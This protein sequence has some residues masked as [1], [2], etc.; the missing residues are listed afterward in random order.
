MSVRG[1]DDG[2]GGD[3]DVER[4]RKTAEAKGLELDDIEVEKD[5]ND[6][7]DKLKRFLV[8]ETKVED[9][10]GD[11]LEADSVGVQITKMQDMQMSDQAF[12]QSMNSKLSSL[13]RYIRGGSE[14][15]DD[16]PD[17]EEVDRDDV[18]GGKSE[19]TRE[20]TVERDVDS[21]VGAELDN[22]LARIEQRLDELEERVEAIED[23]AEALDALKQLTE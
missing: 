15:D 1:L 22:E 16:I 21:G 7:G 6:D 4:I 11:T 17:P 20:R 8:Y 19:T 10:N 13:V 2:G 5:T 9:D 23:K 14:Q 12:Q 3:S 18:G